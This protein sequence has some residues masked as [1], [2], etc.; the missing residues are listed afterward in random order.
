MPVSKTPNK[1]E[2]DTDQI[3]LHRPQEGRSNPTSTLISNF[4]SP[5]LWDN[6]LLL[7]KPLEACSQQVWV[8]NGFPSWLSG[9]EST[10]Q[11]WRQEFDPMVRK[12]PWSREWQPTPVFLSAK[13]HGQRSLARC[14]SWGCKRFRRLRDRLSLPPLLPQEINTR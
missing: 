10:C 3:H 5:E 1:A 13:S 11:C 12:I 9:K 6:T 7:Y 14:S 8:T 4:W 2:K